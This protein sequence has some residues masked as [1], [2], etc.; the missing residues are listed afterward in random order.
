MWMAVGVDVDVEVD[1]V[2]RGSVAARAYEYEYRGLRYLLE[3]RA[4]G[5]PT[6][7]VD[8]AAEAEPFF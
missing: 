5:W 2:R 8:A 7:V 3:S 6:G 1:V 4:T